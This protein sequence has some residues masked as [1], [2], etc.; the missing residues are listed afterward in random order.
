MNV[1]DFKTRVKLQKRGAG[2]WEDQAQAWA[3][4]HYMR[5]SETVLAGRLAGRSTV[6]ITVSTNAVVRSAETAWRIKDAV[7][8]TVFNIKTIIPG[9]QFTDFTCETGGLG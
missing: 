1:G 9:D 7:R 8:N 2:Q 5:G 6:V 4:I 3:K